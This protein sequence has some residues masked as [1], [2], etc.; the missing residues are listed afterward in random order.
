MVGKGRSW[1]SKRSTLFAGSVKK[2]SVL[3]S[4][5]SLDQVQNFKAETLKVRQ[6]LVSDTVLKSVFAI[7][8]NGNWRLVA[9]RRMR[10]SSFQ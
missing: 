7:E 1:V 10:G 9:T 5:D 6:P 4:F 3:S 8:T 2:I